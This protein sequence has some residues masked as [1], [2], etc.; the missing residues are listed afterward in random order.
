MSTGLGA[1]IRIFKYLGG[2]IDVGTPLVSTSDSRSGDV[3]ARFRI[4]GE[5]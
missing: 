2:A 1:R 4:W 3:F 5:F